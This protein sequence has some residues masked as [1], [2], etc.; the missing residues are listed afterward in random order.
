[1]R[2]TIE[3]SK[4]HILTDGKV[5]GRKIYLAEDVD[6]SAFYEISESEMPNLEEGEADIEDYKEAL[7]RL[8]VSE[9]E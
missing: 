5:Y 7:A 6:E 4:G 8:G 2:K 9:D 3:A 1:M